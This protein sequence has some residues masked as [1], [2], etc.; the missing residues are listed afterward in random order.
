VSEPTWWWLVY[1]CMSGRV[2]VAPSPLHPRPLGP[3]RAVPVRLILRAPFTPFATSSNPTNKPIHC[4]YSSSSSSPTHRYSYLRIDTDRPA[5]TRSRSTID[6]CC[7]RVR[8]RSFEPIRY[9][10]PRIKPIKPSPPPGTPADAARPS[11][12]L[13]RAPHPSSF[14]YNTI[15]PIFSNLRIAHT[16]A[17]AVATT[18]TKHD[19][20]ICRRDTRS[21]HPSP[22]LASPRLAAAPAPTLPRATA[23]RSRSL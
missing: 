3:P 18:L 2:N 21:H 1:V 6:C 19:R 5:P 4:S 10:Y 7:N 8:K 17:T 14:V 13:P 23:V 22:R 9:Y 11:F 12:P 20:S 16:T 15:I